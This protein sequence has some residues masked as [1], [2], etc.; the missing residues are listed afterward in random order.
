MG[1][2]PIQPIIQPITIDTMLNNNG[3][4]IGDGLNSLR[5]N[6]PLMWKIIDRSIELFWQL[7]TPHLTLA[8][9]C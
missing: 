1:D 2:G 3:L 4:N 6:R 5:V 9:V 7:V 8:S